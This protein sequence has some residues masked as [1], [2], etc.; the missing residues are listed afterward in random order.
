M[1]FKLKMKKSERE[2]G[3]T[4]YRKRLKDQKKDGRIGTEL[5]CQTVFL[6]R[7]V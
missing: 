1:P 4:K 3:K 6:G 7:C 2:T 5:V